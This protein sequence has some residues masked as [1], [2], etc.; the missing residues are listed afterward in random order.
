ML[1]LQRQ[2]LHRAIAEYLEEKHK[3]NLEAVYALLAYHWCKV[4]QGAT[5]AN[6]STVKR[7][8]KFVEKAIEQATQNNQNADVWI[9][10]SERLLKL[11]PSSKAGLRSQL[12]ISL[13]QVSLL[14]RL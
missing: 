10:R 3:D 14:E 11:L 12:K 1:Y 4:F 13:S 7:A 6:P 9:R 2:K 5:E 8:I